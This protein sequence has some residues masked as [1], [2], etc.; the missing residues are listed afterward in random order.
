MAD[1]KMVIVVRKDLNMRKGKIGAQCGHAAELFLIEG[2]TPGS[3]TLTVHLT[4]PM[5]AWLGNMITKAVVSVN[6]EQELLDLIEQGKRAGIDVRS[7]T[8]AGVTEFHG[9]PTLTCAAFGPDDVQKIN[10]VTGHLPLL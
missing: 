7:V 4:P 10:H 2:Y 9:V 5:I 6:S 3:D 8:D 1:Y